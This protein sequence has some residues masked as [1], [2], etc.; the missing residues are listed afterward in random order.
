MRLIGLT[1]DSIFYREAQP[2]GNGS[3]HTWL[4]LNE[5]GTP[6]DIGVSLT[7]AA[8]SGL[9]E[10]SETFFAVSDTKFQA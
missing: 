6:S 10:E 2:L 5:D 3:T 7:E 8:L 4:K 1:S 9:P